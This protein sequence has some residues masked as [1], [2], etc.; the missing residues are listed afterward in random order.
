MSDSKDSIVTYTEVP[1]SLDYVPD[2]EEREQAP[3]SPEFVPE[4]VYPEFMPPEDEV[5]PAEEQPLPAAVSPTTDS[6]GYIVESDLEEDEE[7][8]EENPTNYPANRGDDDDDD[9]ESS[10]DDEDDDDDVEEDEDEV[11]EEEHPAPADSVLPPIH[12]VTAR[13]S[14]RDQPPT[15]F[16][17]EAKIARLLAIPSPL[18]SPLSLLS[19]PLPQIPS[20]P[21][22]VSSPVH[23]SPPPL[24]ASPTY[25]LGYRASMIRLRA[26]TPST[27]HP[28]P[29]STPPSGTPPLLPIPLP[30]SSPPLLLPSTDC[31]A[32]VSEVTLPPRKRMC[33]ALGL[34]YEVGESSSAPTARPIRGFR[35]DYGFV[36]TLDDEIRRDPERDV[37]YKI[38]DN[39]DEMLMGMPGAPATDETELGQTLTNF[40][41]TVRQD[42]DEIYGRLDDAQDDRSLMSVQSMD[43][44]D[45]ARSEVRALRT[46]ILAQQ[47]KIE[48]LRAV[49]E[50]LS[51]QGPASGPTQ[52]EIPKEAGQTKKMAPKK[53]TRSTLATTTTTTFVT[54]AQLKALIDQGV[55][56]AL[57]ARD[58]DR[59][60][61][62]DDSHNSRTG[63][64]RQAPPARECTY[65]DFMKCKPLYFKGTERFDAIE[66]ATELIDKKIRTFAERQSE[67]KRKQDDNQQ[68]QQNKRQNTCRAYAARS[69]EKKPYGGSKP[70]CSKCNYH[71][72]G[73]CAPKCHKCNRVGHLARDCRSTTNGNAANN[74]RVTKAGQKP[75]CYEC[76]AQGYFKRDYP[77]LKNKNR[78]N[79]SGNSNA[80]AKVYAVGHA[81]TNPDSNVVTGTFLLNNRFVSVLFD[82]GANRSFVSTTFR[83]QIDITPSTL[84]HY[85]DVE[86][87]N[88]RI[89]GLNAIIR[90]CTL[91]LLNH[92][93][94]IDLMPVEL[95]SLDVIIGMIGWQSTKLSL[96]MPRKSFAFLG[97]MK[98]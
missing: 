14:I 68:Q 64:R 52:P 30:T 80:L 98:P 37:G 76:R 50:L 87:A 35:V 26:K 20:P 31:R 61:N 2:L 42:T 25:P 60:M 18:P 53:A 72:D 10:D 13:M 58:A 57:A 39:W 29:S 78:G 48:G 89:I 63:V 33:I 62:G 17:Y 46:T 83:S 49:T 8:H 5:F 59:S 69:D 73:Q 88:G 84:D 86:L 81:R 97:E 74:Q 82:I 77:K 92:P 27:S 24:P 32:G 95:G 22:P 9:D 28:L 43:A 11:E 65:P 15:P 85:Y 36:A 96:F 75:T 94:N 4:P 21:L 56:D 23:V 41:T 1:P 12:R 71:H 67:N 19:S 70:L 3:L 16:W 40:V 91:N 45:T 55:A 34:R 38:T 6:P 47:T 66:F 79:Q 51:Q 44:S 7:D 93:F 54:N 90:G